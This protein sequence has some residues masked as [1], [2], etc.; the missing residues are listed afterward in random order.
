MGVDLK[1]NVSQKLFFTQSL[2]HFLKRVRH[3]YHTWYMKTMV[4]KL[5]RKFTAQNY[6]TAASAGFLQDYGKLSGLT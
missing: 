4:C 6:I 5:T 3:V 1:I 2:H